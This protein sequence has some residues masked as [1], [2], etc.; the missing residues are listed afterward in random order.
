MILFINFFLKKSKFFYK[1]RVKKGWAK[2]NTA[3]SVATCT[4]VVDMVVS[5]TTVSL[6][7]VN[8]VVQS[9]AL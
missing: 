4:A 7:R 9:G 1:N 3:D 5:P 8:F 2:G 6:Q